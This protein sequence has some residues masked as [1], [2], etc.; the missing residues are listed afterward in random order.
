MKIKL[1]DLE[2]GKK[3]WCGCD[4]GFCQENIEEVE[5]IEW[6]FDEDTGE[7]YKVIMLSG[8]RKFDSRNGTAM[9]SPAAYYL[10]PTEQ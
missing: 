4:S 7:K 10:S 6:K 5:K 9:N 1:K 2:T 3:V 8:G